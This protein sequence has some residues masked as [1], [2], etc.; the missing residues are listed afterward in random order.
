M[1]KIITSHQRPPIPTRKVDWV[2]FYD[3]EEE[4]GEYGYGET[5]E[6]AIVDLIE[7]YPDESEET[8]D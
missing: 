1:K 5:E 3:G 2:A 4:R 6:E 8:S 7:N